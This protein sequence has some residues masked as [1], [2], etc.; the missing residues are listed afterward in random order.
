MF[1][2]TIFAAIIFFL[3]MG[4]AWTLSSARAVFAPLIAAGLSAWVLFTV[5]LES[6]LYALVYN[7]FVAALSGETLSITG[8]AG[9]F[10][11]LGMIWVAGIAF[12][13]G[14]SSFDRSGHIE[15]FQ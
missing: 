12:V 15:L 8:W 5:S 6:A 9:I 3:L 7:P 2:G 1:D 10:M 4:M 11:A 13:N 14:V